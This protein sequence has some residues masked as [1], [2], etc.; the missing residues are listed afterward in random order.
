[1]QTLLFRAIMLSALSVMSGCERAPR[2]P[3]TV[4]TAQ[5][6][7]PDLLTATTTEAMCGTATQRA[8]AI[9]RIAEESE[10]NS[11]P[12]DVYSVASDIATKGCTKTGD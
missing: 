2:A 5:A 6:E 11:S 3:A 7:K 8:H 1:M 9:G 4:V 12:D 10:I